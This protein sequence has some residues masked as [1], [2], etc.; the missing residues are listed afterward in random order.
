MRG[1]IDSNKTYH[2][3]IDPKERADQLIEKIELSSSS[4][5]SLNDKSSETCN[6]HN[7]YTLK[8]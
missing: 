5:G 8:Q 2:I 4:E 3:V 6:S 7:V 1:S